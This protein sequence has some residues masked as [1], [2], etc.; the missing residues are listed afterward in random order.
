[1]NPWKAARLEP[2]LWVVPLQQPSRVLSWAVLGGGLV[3][4]DRVVWLEVNNRE[5]GPGVDPIDLARDRLAQR[6]LSGAVTFMTSHP[7][8]GYQEVPLS[9]EDLH[10]RCIA[11]V[12]L[13]NARRIGDPPG[14]GR[15]GTINVLVQLNKPLSDS[16]LVEALAMAAE[17]RTAAC[18][19]ADLPSPVSGRP[20]TGTGTDCI[21]VAC[22]IVAADPLRY[23]GKHTDVGAVIGQSVI[24]AVGAGI[25][26][27]IAT[28]LGLGAM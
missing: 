23:A 9:R 6:D 26:N 28:T 10:C 18:L 15:L 24:A 11:T 14:E 20:I 17:A 5:L 2:G 13:G 1:M 21:A 12:G 22:P 27:W 25:Q 7:V 19:E 16:A 4:A 8:A 3:A